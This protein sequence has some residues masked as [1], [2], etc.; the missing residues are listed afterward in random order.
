M[1]YPY[2][3]R[4][5]QYVGNVSILKYFA[6]GAAMCAAYILFTCLFGCAVLQQHSASAQSRADGCLE[7][8]TVEGCPIIRRMWS[9]NSYSGTCQQ[10]FVCSNHTNAFQDQDTCTETC[11][12]VSR[13]RPPESYKDCAFWLDRLH[14]C[15]QKWLTYHLDYRRRVQQLLIYTRCG[16][17]PHKRYGY[18]VA[19][20]RC[21]ELNLPPEWTRE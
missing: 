11:A 2:K 5:R 10:N 17:P 4:K 15:K 6:R 12:S 13:P 21:Q 16:S 3:Y 1:K 8:P 19:T 7:T 18:Y 20:G 14:L 9:F